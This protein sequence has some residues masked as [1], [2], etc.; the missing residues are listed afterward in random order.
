MTG[1]V[2][3][4]AG[5]SYPEKPRFV[6]WEGDRYAVEAIIDQHREPN[7]IGFRVL[8]QPGQAVFDLLYQMDSDTWEI[9]LVGAAPTE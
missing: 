3:C 1:Q 4:Y 5:S 2:E 9:R 8:C 6:N 7:G